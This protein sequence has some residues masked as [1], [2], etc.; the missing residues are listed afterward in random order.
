MS[1]ANDNRLRD[2][3]MR[4]PIGAKPLKATSVPPMK[5]EAFIRFH[6]NRRRATAPPPPTLWRRI[7]DRIIEWL[8]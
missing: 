5:L 4:G 2:A 7:K 8:Q 3:L 1:L 6:Q